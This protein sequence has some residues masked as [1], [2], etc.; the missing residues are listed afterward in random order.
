MSADILIVDDEA[1]IRDLIAGVLEDEGYETREAA[2][3]DECLAAVSNRCPNLIVL[4]IW[5]RGSRLDG[6]EILQEIKKIAPTVPVIMISGHGNIETAVNTIKLGA[7]D[8]IEKPFKADRLMQVVERALEADRLKRENHELRTKGGEVTSE[9]VYRSNAMQQLEQAIMRVAPTN[10]RVMI[11]GPSGSGKEIVA[12]MIHAHS[13]RANGPFVV[14]NAATMAPDLLEIQLFG[15][16]EGRMISNKGNRRGLLEQAHGG[17]IFLDEVVDMPLETQGKILRVLVDQSFQRVGGSEKVKVDVRVT[18]S[19]SH[20]L[21][22]AMESGRLREDLFH[23]L[24]VV[25]LSVPPLKDRPEDIAPLAR[26]FIERF[27]KSTGLS[28]RKI[29]EDAIA[30]LQASMWP[31][32]VR[33]LKNVIEQIMI[34]ATGDRDAPITADMIPSEASLASSVLT[35]KKDQTEIMALPLR[36]A[37]ERFEKE[38]LEA[39]VNRFGGNISRTASF[40]GMERSALH[41]KLKSLGVHNGERAKEQG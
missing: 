37:R 1:D 15:V 26:F 35:G 23:R 12:R 14:L 3:S 31:G 16:E 39:Q 11:T 27:A 17:T 34:L 13:H 8:F 25:P 7:Y 32:N 24:S 2:N 33:Q 6:I 18:S 9:L 41:R 40:V 29:T 22:A 4:D 10:S 36:E 21:Q 30:T 19:S 28:V 5:L 38:Y 20:D